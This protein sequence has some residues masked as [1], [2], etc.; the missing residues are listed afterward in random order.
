MAR[1]AAHVRPGARVCRLRQEPGESAPSVAGAASADASCAHGVPH[2]GPLCLGW[3]CTRADWALPAAPVRGFV[4]RH[5]PSHPISGMSRR[6]RL[7]NLPAL[8]TDLR[9]CPGRKPASPLWR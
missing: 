4:T 3:S 7:S 6:P 5:E 2:P 1:T 9:L 8:F